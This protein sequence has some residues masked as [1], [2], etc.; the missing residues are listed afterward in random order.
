MLTPPPLKSGDLIRVVAPSSRFDYGRFEAGIGFLKERGFRVAF[1]DDIDA[2]ARYLAGDDERRADELRE[3]LA[4]QEATAIWCVRG[5]YGAQRLYPLLDTFEWSAPKWLVGFS[6]IT[7]L[8]GWVRR[9]GYQSLH[10]PN[11]T[12]LTDW[13][14]EAQA[15]TF[16]LLTEAPWAG[17]SLQG[18]DNAPDEIQGRLVGGN[19][20]VLASLMG[21][22][23]Q[24]FFKNEI[25]CLEDVGER[26]Y[27]LDRSLEQLIQAGVLDGVAGVILGN[28][29]NCNEERDHETVIDG[30]EVLCERLRG[31]NIPVFTHGPFGHHQ[32]SRAFRHGELVHVTRSEKGGFQASPKKFLLPGVHI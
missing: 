11:V 5:G 28:F 2:S 15:E 1:R 20:T 4:D 24:P 3:A 10:G 18:A 8:H 29:L 30:H 21:S 17:W 31:L 25:L 27:R 23:E 19:L 26:P 9:R 12:T 7:A 32:A 6:D 14:P 22:E 13:T 16:D